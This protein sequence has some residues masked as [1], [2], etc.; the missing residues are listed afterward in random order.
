[1]SDASSV[2]SSHSM[3]SVS[4]TKMSCPYC[5]KDL[6]IR[7]MFNHI[8]KI[9]PEEILKSTNRRWIEDAEAGKPFRL[10]W[11]STNDFDEVDYTTLYACL[12]TNK[13]FTTELGARQHFTK[14][15]KALKEH[16]AELK[17]LKK[18]FQS[19]KKA[20]AKKKVEAAKKHAK[21]DPYMIRLHEA[22]ESN[23][24]ELARA[25]WRGILNNKTICECAMT[26]CRRRNFC[27]ETRMYIRDAKVQLFEE[28]SFTEF[29]ER[30]QATMAKIQAAL[31]SQC[32]NTKALHRLF[33]ES[34]IW[35]FTNFEESI[36]GY[37]EDMLVL[38]PLYRF[39]LNGDE[40][41]FYYA[42]EEMEG[43]SF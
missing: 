2:C 39:L 27:H 22:R 43:V 40:K 41:F 42:L 12:G 13:T 7:A 24:P 16:N 17:A 15:K 8:R 3:T 23:S 10:C 35:A 29:C 36:F 25:I 4:L 21:T 5:A 20:E 28:V 19:F 14:D 26:I 38:H 32:L 30:Y 31:D 9:H 37:K 11:E 18:Q 34:M 1:M 6:Q 33:S